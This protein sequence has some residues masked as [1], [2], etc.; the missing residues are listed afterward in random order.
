MSFSTIIEELGLG[1][2]QTVVFIVSALCVS[3]HLSLTGIGAPF[4]SLCNPK[5]PHADK[6]YERELKP[7]FWTNFPCGR[8]ARDAVRGT[9]QWSLLLVHRIFLDIAVVW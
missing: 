5:R 8:V 4:E 2:M 1:K 3:G 6:T 7:L 9:F